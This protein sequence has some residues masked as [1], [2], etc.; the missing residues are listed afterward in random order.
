M[1]AHEF[2]NVES[3]LSIGT[4]DT[5]QTRTLWAWVDELEA[6]EEMLRPPPPP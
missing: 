4:G 5:T 1:G 3:A 6:R 2:G